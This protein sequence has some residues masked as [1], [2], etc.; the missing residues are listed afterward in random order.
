MVGIYSFK[1]ALGE[2]DYSRPAFI[3]GNTVFYMMMPGK[4][5]FQMLMRDVL[6]N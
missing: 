3:Q 1:E 4:R 5:I 6:E 2:G